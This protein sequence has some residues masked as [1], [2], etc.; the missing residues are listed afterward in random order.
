MNKWVIIFLLFFLSP[1]IVGA[2][3]FNSYKITSEVEGTDVREDLFITLFND[4]DPELRT[5]SLTLPRNS[6]VLSVR[7]TYGRLPYTVTGKETRMLSFTFSEAIKPGEERVI[8]LELKAPLVSRKDGYSEYLLLF[9]PRQ[10]IKD[11]EHILRLPVDAELF[12][13]SESYPTVVPDAE[14][15]EVSG[16]LVLTW[17]TSLEADNPVVFLVRYK[18]PF[19]SIRRTIFIALSA[20][21]SLSLLFLVGRELRGRRQRSKV[22]SSLKI[23]NERER[24]VIAEIVKDE[25]IK[26]RELMHLLGYTK[27]S[28]SKI[29]SRLEA[30]GLVKKVK[31]GKINRL[32]PGERIK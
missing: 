22:L 25:G 16:G 31:S 18:S 19:Y 4:G 21:V 8:I 26:Q 2:V 12:S 30:R 27:S 5:A 14:I 10:E 32:Y 9:N 13:P 20:L 29:I 17:R 6:E 15:S 3:Q 24:L 7:D 1:A 23:L 11:F 28:L